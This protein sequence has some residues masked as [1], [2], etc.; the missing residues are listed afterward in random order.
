MIQGCATAEGTARYRDRF[1]STL[2]ADH[3]RDLHGL[4]LSSIGIGTY[5]GEPTEEDD[6]AY[7]EAIQ[8]ALLSGSNVVDSAI[9][10]RFQ[11]SERSTGA[12]VAA[13]IAEGAV[14]RDEIIVATKGGFIP[15]D[16][17]WPKD[18]RRWIADNVLRPGLATPADI[19]ADCHCIAP[20]YV[21]HLF[22]CSRR[23]LGVETIDV[24]YVHNP[25]TQLQATDRDTFLHHLHADFEVLERKVLE[26]KLSLYGTA[27]WDG[28]RSPPG[29]PQHL[30]LAE[31]VEAARA[32]AAAVGA[33]H[34]HFGAAQVPLSLAMPEALLHPTQERGPAHGPPAGDRLPFL[35]AAMAKGLIVMGSAT[36]LQGHLAWKMPEELGARIPGGRSNAQKAIQ[37]ARSAP[38]LAV[39]LVGMRSRRHVVENL[40]LAR[41]PRMTR[42]QFTAFLTPKR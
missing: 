21:D 30:S 40:E 10:Y 15:F 42:E 37:W 13:L 9:N 38:G 18:P 12:A 22:E 17:G 4:W 7:V 41:E 29:H 39:A 33:K 8:E 5:L 24:Y 27:T 36:I 3:F 34:H 14:A 28:Y 26:G 19:V 23:N 20:A 16:G 35:A 25:E 6:R 32:A 1:A 31:V 11:R 2:A